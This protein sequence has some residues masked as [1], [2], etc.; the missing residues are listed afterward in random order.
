MNLTP[1]PFAP[2]SI[3]PLRLLSLPLY[4]A[5]A[6]RWKIHL[7]SYLFPRFDGPF[8]WDLMVL[9]LGNKTKWKC[10]SI[11]TD[12]KP[13]GNDGHLITCTTWE[14]ERHRLKHT[15][16]VGFVSQPGTLWGASLLKG[17][18][19]IAP[20]GD[21]SISQHNV[22]SRGACFLMTVISVSL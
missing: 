12:S 1:C 2:S 20:K 22:P 21:E 6:W 19:Q 5:G 3:G 9:F 18:R 17:E 14:Y 7:F 10:K 13:F 16:K 15:P 4:L 11:N 8:P